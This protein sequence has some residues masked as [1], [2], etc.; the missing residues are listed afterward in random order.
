MDC[1]SGRRSFGKGDFR[2]WLLGLGLR[3]IG[4]KFKGRAIAEGEME[5][6][7]VGGWD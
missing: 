4:F 7:G 1:M 2:L 3:E 5:A 6:F